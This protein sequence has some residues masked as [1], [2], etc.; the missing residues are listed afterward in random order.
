M[1]KIK[2]IIQ[3]YTF[4]EIRKC[5]CCLVKCICGDRRP[6]CKWIFFAGCYRRIGRALGPVCVI[7]RAVTCVSNKNGA[8]PEPRGWID[9][10]RARVRGVDVGVA[11]RRRRQWVAARPWARPLAGRPT[12]PAAPTWV[13]LAQKNKH[14]YIVA[15]ISFHSALIQ[16]GELTIGRL[17][18]R[19]LVA[20]GRGP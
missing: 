16:S 18:K 7:W 1:L 15:M 8:I 19:S 4:K 20:T 6:L 2:N 12:S 11:Q 17:L 9:G 13:L 3:N 10:G 5:V 14:A